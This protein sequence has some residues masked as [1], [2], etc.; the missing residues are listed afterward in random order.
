MC[1]GIESEQ[2]ERSERRKSVK[3][4]LV[5]TLAPRVHEKL[6]DRKVEVA[7]VEQKLHNATLHELSQALQNPRALFAEPEAEDSIRDPTRASQRP[8]AGG[9]P[10][11]ASGA[12]ARAEQPGAR[13][14][15]A[16]AGAGAATWTGTRA[17]PAPV[18]LPARAASATTP[19]PAGLPT[20]AS[21][22]PARP[23]GARAV[24]DRELDRHDLPRLLHR[25][26]HG[27]PARA[28]RP[29]ACRKPPKVL[30]N[31]CFFGIFGLLGG[32]AG[33]AGAHA[34]AV[35]ASC[36]A[37]GRARGPAGR[38]A[39]ARPSQRQQPQRSRPQPRQHRRA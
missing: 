18:S 13:E 8:R 34:G 6:G 11:E 29:Q 4:Q 32:P 33:P 36:P 9:A 30:K 19:A 7:D 14:S 22:A 3:E 20:S 15:R 1:G 26:S 16:P 28:T 5:G 37:G 27:K 39:R 35:G 12:R 25:E 38:P 21:A 2:S 10:G 17:P 31:S 24:S 23:S